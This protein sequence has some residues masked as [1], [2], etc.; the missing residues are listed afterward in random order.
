MISVKSMSKFRLILQRVTS[1]R[2]CSAPSPVN[3]PSSLQIKAPSDS[4]V[5]TRNIMGP[6][7]RHEQPQTTVCC[8]ILQLLCQHSS[9]Q[10]VDCERPAH[11]VSPFTTGTAS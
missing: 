11:G 6:L 8:K 7:L 1:R 4:C 10:V 3:R 5:S 2:T 9:S